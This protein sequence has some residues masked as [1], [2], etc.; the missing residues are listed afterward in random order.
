M[1]CGSQQQLRKKSLMRN[2]LPLLLV[3]S[4][5]LPACGSSSDPES[6]RVK[7][8]IEDELVIDG[9]GHTYLTSAM[10]QALTSQK[11]QCW[12]PAISGVPGYTDLEVSNAPHV[13][14]EFGI[15]PALMDTNGWIKTIQTWDYLDGDY[16]VLYLP[17]DQLTTDYRD[18]WWYDRH[19]N[20]DLEPGTPL[21]PNP[22]PTGHE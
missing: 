16:I 6:E 21:C 12:Y 10:V 1:E 9:P 14:F 18:T 13:H 19:G 11:H 15:F 8:Q 2:F 17:K 20:Y 7:L 22:D 4:L 3:L 5:L